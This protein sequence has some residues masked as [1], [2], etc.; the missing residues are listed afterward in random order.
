M[1]IILITKSIQIEII[2]KKYSGK[3]IEKVHVI[4][5][6]KHYKPKVGRTQAKLNND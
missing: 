4:S 2:T 3:I 6:C 5:I 1:L